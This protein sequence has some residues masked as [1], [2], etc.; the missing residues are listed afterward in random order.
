MLELKDKQVLVIG[1]GPAGRAACAL[2]RRAGAQVV[3]VDSANT[4]ALR[5]VAEQLRS[6]GVQVELGIATV[7]KRPF[8]LAIVTPGAAESPLIAAVESEGIP[9]ISELELGCQQAKCLIIAIAGTNGKS[10]TAQ[11]VERVL[12]NNHRKIAFAGGAERPVS[13]VAEDTRELDFLVV[14]AS[15]LELERSPGL[16]PS[17]AVLLNVAPDHLDHYASPGDYV[18]ANTNLF[19]NQQAFD[20]AIVQTEAL[21]ELKKLDLLPPSKVV[22]FSAADQKS[23]LY[24]DRGL[25]ISRL[26]NWNGPLLNTDQCQ[27]R[28]PHNAENL[29]AAAAVGHALRLPLETMVDTFKSHAPA[30]HRFQVVDEINGVQFINDAKAANVDALRNAL[31]AARTGREGGANVWLIAGGKDKGLDFHS[32]GPIVSKRVRGAFLIGD[33]R[34]KISSAWSLFTP[35]TLADSLLEAITEAAKKA[36]PGDVILFSPACS[37]FDQSQ[38]DQQNGERFCGIVKSISRGGPEADPNISRKITIS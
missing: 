1:L 19:R 36:S 24:L 17:V 23:D 3:A 6:D 30:P 34:Q 9:A 21:A 15:A 12:L 18:R 32:V 16:K 35:C 8:A 26:E 25:I 7:P 5:D 4:E 27:L 20:W 31:L 13:A 14:Q 33:A 37:S 22:T 11:L 29:M 28:G 10:T 2:L 38:N